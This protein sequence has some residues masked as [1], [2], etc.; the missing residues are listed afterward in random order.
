MSRE[1]WYLLQQV[2]EIFIILELIDPLRL[3]QYMCVYG[4]IKISLD[5][6]F[7]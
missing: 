3:G 4:D 5:C 1:E 7:Q 6:P 2:M